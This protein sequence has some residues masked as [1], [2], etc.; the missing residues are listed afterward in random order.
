MNTSTT[1]VLFF[2][3]FVLPL[4]IYASYLMFYASDMYESEAGLI[5]TEERGAPQA[6]DL[7]L[8][9]L[10][11]QSSDRDALVLETFMLSRDLIVKLNDRLDFRKHY[12]QPSADWWMR[13]DPTTSVEGLVNYMRSHITVAYDVDAKIL[14]V[15]IRS[16]DRDYSRKLLEQLIAESQTFMDNLN[17]RVAN[18]QTRFFEDKLAESEKR[19]RA[20]KEELV[21]F[22]RQN[23]L[24]TVQ[25]E[26]DVIL[27]NVSGLEK[28]LVEKQSLMSTLKQTL[29]AGAPQL[30]NLQNEID[31][32]RK[33][34]VAERER[35]SG[36]SSAALTEL[37]A[38][39][40]EIELNLEFVTTIYKSNLSQLEQMR[41]DAAKRQ[42]FLV[43]VTTPSLA[44]E[45]SYP[46]RPYQ[47]ATAALVLLVAYFV[48]SLMT[49]VL[50]ERA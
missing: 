22:Q 16:F 42:K 14:T 19:L 46:D 28:S 7:T 21:E 12:S 2:L 27:Q 45:S 9:G 49:A 37:D 36:N 31:S 11:S 33:Q 48:I 25:A 41:Y 13:L 34:L 38:R 20:A 50:R 35:L 15:S 44:D 40:R 26:G 3:I 17:E 5:I 39:S 18:E 10:P 6:V 32:I 23:R 30:A 47:I 1:R 24:L 29:S 43:V 8:L 4:V